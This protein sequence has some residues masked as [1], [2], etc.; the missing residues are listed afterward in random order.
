MASFDTFPL[1]LADVMK[2]VVLGTGDEVHD[3]DFDAIRERFAGSRF[4]VEPHRYGP[5][6]LARHR[7]QAAR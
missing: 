1:P 5:R 2:I 4:T 7:P 3:R 6:R